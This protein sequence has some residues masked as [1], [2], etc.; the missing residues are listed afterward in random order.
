MLI[1]GA[2]CRARGGLIQPMAV[3]IIFTRF[4]RARAGWRSASIHCA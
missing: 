4:P 1:V 2:S 3:L